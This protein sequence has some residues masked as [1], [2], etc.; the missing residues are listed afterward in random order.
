MPSSLARDR[1]DGL[2]NVDIRYGDLLD[3]GSLQSA[4][5]E[6]KPD[7]IYN[8][9]D[10]DHVGW[11]YQIPTYSFNVTTNSVM[12][13]LE[14][15]RKQKK[16]IK[17]FQPISSNIFGHS[18]GKKFNENSIMDPHSIYALGK[19]STYMLCRMYKKLYNIKIYGAIFFN[20][21]SPKR[22]AEY[23]SQ[24][25]IKHACEIAYKKRKYFDSYTNMYLYRYITQ[26][27]VI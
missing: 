13:I 22:S 12:T 7:E 6:F 14:I 18:K 3:E 26:K 5:L 1:I 11:S 19:A 27:L 24:K 16:K 17:Y 4:L 2:D 23:V 20:H 8:F 15:L 25:I 9:A 21:E 10:Q